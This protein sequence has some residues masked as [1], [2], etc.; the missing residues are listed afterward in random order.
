L[1]FFTN[2]LP[3]AAKP[4]TARTAL[5]V[6]VEICISLRSVPDADSN[7][8]GETHRRKTLGA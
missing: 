7:E 2:I 6:L 4:L 3:S 5:L 1:T 8:R